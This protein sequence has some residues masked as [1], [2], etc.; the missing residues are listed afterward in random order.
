VA[1]DEGAVA[2]VLQR[3][4]LLRALRRAFGQLVWRRHGDL[5]VFAIDQ[6]AGA[7]SSYDPTAAV[8]RL[9]VVLIF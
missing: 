7:P 1:G 9:A 8:D 4:L 6:T 5:D 2:F 3:R